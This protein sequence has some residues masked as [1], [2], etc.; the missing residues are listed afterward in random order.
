MFF[1]SKETDFVLKLLKSIQGEIWIKICRNQEFR[2]FNPTQIWQAIWTS[3]IW[4]AIWTSTCSGRKVHLIARKRRNHF[5]FQKE[6]ICDLLVAQIWFIWAHTHVH[7]VQSKSKYMQGTKELNQRPD[8][9]AKDIFLNLELKDEVFSGELYHDRWSK[10]HLPQTISNIAYIDLE[11]IAMLSTHVSKQ[12]G[13]LAK[14]CIFGHIGLK[15]YFS[16]RKYFE[17]W[18]IY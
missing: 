9:P 10:I 11:T 12:Y 5:F 13:F 3:K 1:V 4:Q 14:N 2:H 18:L 17:N 16:K 15:L 7:N 8:L 6:E